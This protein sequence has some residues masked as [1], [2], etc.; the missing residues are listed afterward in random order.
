[1][2]L[3]VIFRFQYKYEKS[4]RLNNKKQENYYNIKTCKFVLTLRKI[5]SI[6]YDFEHFSLHLQPFLKIL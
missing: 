1:M 4:S 2:N 6:I 5:Q 3:P